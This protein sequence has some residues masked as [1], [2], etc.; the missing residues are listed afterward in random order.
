MTTS[1]QIHLGLSLTQNSTSI[2][3]GLKYLRNGNVSFLVAPL[4]LRGKE[5][6]SFASASPFVLEAK[7]RVDTATWCHVLVGE[8]SDS[9]GSSFNA[10]ID[11]SRVRD[12]LEQ[13]I[14]WAKFLSL[15]T[16]SLPKCTPS[17][18][19]YAY[20]MRL[21]Q[22]IH[23]S[24]ATFWQRMPLTFSPKETNEGT[25]LSN[26]MDS[27]DYWSILSQ[28]CD[29]HPNL[30]LALTVSSKLPSEPAIKRWHSEPVSC[31]IL[32]TN[33]FISNSSGYPVLPKTYQAF[34][35]EFLLKGVQVVIE[36]HPNDFRKAQDAPSIACDY[37]HYFAYLNFL[38]NKIPPLDENEKLLQHYHDLLQ[39]PLQPLADNLESGT[40]E[41]FERD[42]MKYTQYQ[43]AIERAFLEE[44]SLQPTESG[45]GSDRP[46]RI[47]IVGAG[48]G[49][50]VRATMRAAHK[51]SRRV[52]VIAL[53]KNPNAIFLLSQL[54]R[55][56]NWDN[57]SIVEADMR[58]WEPE[59][60][61]DI[62]LSELL[63]SFGDNELSPE[64]LDGVMKFLRS[65]GIS[66]PSSYNSYMAPV[67]APKAWKS[68]KAFADNR[69]FEVPYVTLL[70]QHVLLDRPKLIF[71]F[72][73]VPSSDTAFPYYRNTRSRMEQWTVDNGGLNYILHGFA[74]YFDCVLY[75]D[76]T[77]SI[78]PI[79][80]TPHMLSWFPMFFP[81]RTPV[82][83][84]EGD[85]IKLRI[86]R[87]I[88]P[89]SSC[90]KKVWYEWS[91]FAPQVSHVHNIGGRRYAIRL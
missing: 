60:K 26:T 19:V 18:D 67:M 17:L 63:G 79:N 87:E 42:S 24:S 77:L 49:P 89:P 40:Y 21:S 48:R 76:I 81:L 65:S 32:P 20:A 74:G 91:L 51:T 80:H 1:T 23:S 52:T 5:P 16:L 35:L 38:I 62:I 41:V 30:T 70:T 11:S 14:E 61:F 31:I 7:E 44:A 66:I 8:L 3:D 22:L 85:P 54:L 71:N 9:L 13:D 36:G 84:S 53:E 29:Y 25:D 10:N 88:S 82:R 90:E 56:E 39:T 73:H 47:A 4:F 68:V 2:E 27:W 45:L 46:I 50:L 58:T 75:K 78:N 72:E 33:V 43:L 59:E 55:E 86:T 64:C 34:L 12:I 69:A 15:T 83:V 6:G 28:S 57:V 37:A